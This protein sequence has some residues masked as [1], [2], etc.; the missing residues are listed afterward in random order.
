MLTM[1]QVYALYFLRLTY[2]V[3][4]LIFNCTKQVYNR[5]TLLWIHLKIMN[6]DK[7]MMVPTCHASLEAHLYVYNLS[8]HLC[9]VHS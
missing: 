3:K 7:P 5:L 1:I 9:Q 8:E 2:L 6:L 4:C